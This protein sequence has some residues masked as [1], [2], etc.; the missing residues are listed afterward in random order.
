ML[1]IKYDYNMLGIFSSL[2][3]CV[4]HDVTSKAQPVEVKSKVNRSSGLG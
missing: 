1:R 3:K 4:S 2:V